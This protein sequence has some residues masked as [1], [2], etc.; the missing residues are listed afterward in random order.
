MSIW[1]QLV[2]GCLVVAAAVLGWAAYVPAALPWLDKTGL[3]Q[4]LRDF[5]IVS[6]P[7]AD[8]A[9]QERPSGA[10][11]RGPV[12]VASAAEKRVLKDSVTAV[13]SA[14]GARAIVLQAEVT[15][16]I[17][18]MDVRPGQYVESGAVIV[19]LDSEAAQIAVDRAALILADARTTSDRVL[20]LQARG[21][22]TD[23]Q[24]QEAEL[25]LKTAELEHREAT[26]ELA[27][28]R[29]LAPISGWVGIL[30]VEIGD[31][32]APG[33][34][35][36]RLEDRS[37]L[38]VD[39]RV[40]E[41]VVSRLK[42]GDSVRAAPLA[43]PGQQLQGRIVALDNR[44]DVTSRSLLV[45]ASIDNADDALR[46]GMAF[47]VELDFVGGEYPAVDP[48]AI[49]WD[50]AGAFVWVVREGRALRLPIRI[51]QRNSDAVLVEADLADGDLVVTEGVQ[52]LRAG[53]EVRVAPGDGA[54]AGT[55]TTSAPR[56]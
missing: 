28:H 50:A 11:S 21:S 4:P 51:V 48:L 53:G 13:G 37:S 1:K 16:Q 15:G 46:A 33:V 45:Q 19:R 49:Q 40:P 42:P 52:S 55:F 34:E 17:V 32:I 9:V 35:I 43:D 10:Q 20:A 6:M 2:L 39:F 54:A 47:L 7:T 41:R 14:R 30:E 18:A 44:V 27:R 38:I 22:A 31:R 23:L 29:I 36:T 5:G 56:G 12:V 24:V 25:A 8:A 3:L 26:F